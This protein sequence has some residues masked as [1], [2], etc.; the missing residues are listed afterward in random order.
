MA[1]ALANLNLFAIQVQHVQRS[2]NDADGTQIGAVSTN[3]LL[4]TG[5]NYTTV[6]APAVY[7]TNRFTHWTYDRFP[8][9]SFRDAW[10][11]SQNPMSFVLVGQT[12]NTAHYLPSTRDTDGDGLPDG[13]EIEYFNTLSYT[14]T[15]DPDGDGVPLATE[16][17]NGLHPLLGNSNSL[18]GVYWADSTMINVNLQG[19]PSYVLRSIPAGTVN[20]SAVVPPNTA[21]TTP[22]RPGGNT[23]GYWSL[24]GVRQQDP[25]GVAL[26]QISFVVTNTDREA[27]A[28]L[29]SNDSDGD[30]VPDAYEQVYYGSLTNSATSDTDGDGR[31]LLQEYTAGS[32]PHI[33]NMSSEGGVYWA[34]SALMPVNL[35]SYSQY[36]IISDPAGIINQSAFVPDGTRITTPNMAQESF[37]YWTLDGVQQRDGWGMAVRQISFVVEGADREA[38]AHL[39]AGDTDTDG[40]P[41]A[42]EQTYYGTL[43]NDAN[44]DTDGDGRTLLQEYTAG[45]QPHIGNSSS[46]G[47]VY[48]A[49]SALMPVN[50]SNYS[51]YR[52]ISAPTGAIN[53][54]AFVPDGTTITTPEMT[55]ESFG[56]WTLDGVQQR[57]AWGLSVRKISFVVDG[58]DRE[59]VA[60]LFAGDTD[61]DGVPDAFEQTYY[62][63][64]ANDNSSDTDN[65]GRTL[66]QEYTEGSQPHIGNSSSEGGVYWADSEMI[67]VDLVAVKRGICFEEAAVTVVEGSLGVNRIAEIPVF[68]VGP[69]SVTVYAVSG[70]A[71]TADYIWPAAPTTLTWASG[72]AETKM[73]RIPIKTDSLFEQDEVFYLMLGSPT[74][75][76]QI[77]EQRG[78]AVTIKDAN[79]SDKLADALDNLILSWTTS[80]TP[81]WTPQSAMTFDGEDAAWSGA[82]A[83]NKISYVRTSVTGTGTVSFAWCVTGQG[84]LS[85][86]D[87]TKVLLAI[88]NDTDWA[89]QSLRLDNNVT[90]ALKWEY[91]QGGDGLGRAYLDRVVWIPGG[92][93]AV[94]V[95]VIADSPEGGMASGSG[96]YIPGA[97]ISL[98]AKPRAG[99]LFTGW[100]S[101]VP[102][103]YPLSASQTLTVGV[104]DLTLTAHFVKVPV[105]TGIPY[106]PEGGRVTGTGLCLPGKSVTLTATPVTG[107]AFTQWS[108]NSQ[109]ASRTIRTTI[110]VTL[111]AAFKR[112]ADVVPPTIG[113]IQ[114]Q[115]AMVGVPF[116]VPVEMV[117]EALATVTLSGLPAGLSYT[118]ATQSISGVPTV[119]VTNRIVTITAKNANLLPTTRTFLLTIDPLPVWAKGTFSGLVGSEALGS[120]SATM[121]I[122][123]IGNMAGKF[124]L[125]GTNFLFSA[126]AYSAR[127]PDGAFILITT[128]KVG[129]VAW[130]MTLVVSQPVIGDPSN[131]V[132]DT[133]SIADGVLEGR[134]EQVV[135]YRSLWG[136]PGMSAL[137]APLFSGYYTATLPGGNQFG[138]GYLTFTVDKAGMVKTV[139][140]LADGTAIS[141]SG[142]LVLDE[143][144]RVWTVIYTAPTAY[145]GGGLFGVVE[146]VRSPSGVV[147]VQV[148]NSEPFIWENFNPLATGE[149]GAGFLRELGLVG[150]WYDTV[151]NLYRYFGNR[152]L[153]VSTENTPAPEVLVG[154]NRYDAACWDP[155]GL[156]LKVVTNSAGVLTGLVTPKAGTA[157]KVAGEYNY[158]TPTN[159][160]GMTIG[161]TRATGLFKGSFKAWFDYGTTHTSKTITYEGVLTPEKVDPSDPVA[162]RGFFLW[163][164]KAPSPAPL[165]P[166]YFYWSYDLQLL[167]EE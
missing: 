48:W 81:K 167:L 116:E 2:V 8:T 91:K 122:T 50:L 109:I 94:Q 162:G 119:P 124:T 4:G 134:S 44:S 100:T 102:L 18:G 71:T 83:S 40:V 79:R 29:F 136:D 146:F 163:R 111:V 21:I 85:L 121:S 38:V 53:Q 131:M 126:P 153:S 87:G 3:A 73:V 125:R 117:S 159:A 101:G 86:L 120:G 56:Y 45:S 39:F 105:V 151:G 142:M 33:G 164:D 113:E 12:T 166:Y 82:L 160:V 74:S 28:Y 128:A 36:R 90:H 155:D 1:L 72:V 64:L 57:D 103:T 77:G 161:L 30:Q 138:S 26:P 84:I 17:A 60:H 123:A 35:A 115:R 42:F 98:N 47:G 14:G 104:S 106:P 20:Q 129:T 127:E 58:T 148:Y 150:G 31:T 54:S 147:R 93:T 145:R 165:S 132:P 27:I 70:T 66:L 15:S 158:E 16:Y 135:L 80:G 51:Q 7:S 55:Q 13:Y 46:E 61:T 6:T 156:S 89:A 63:T 97:R 149:Y 152:V 114:P 108:D 25:F 67:A 78:C 96:T 52:I 32:L 9:N 144:G 5:T 154:T 157:V 99:W 49:D 95:N 11:R 41:D 76:R 23:F 43:T 19:Y 110:D 130:P 143:T 24:D 92:K 107:W 112:I 62:G 59:A 118:Q 139:G 10:G 133:L 141:L 34:D 68:A 75:G 22:E 69:A 65:D 88:T 37:G 137:L 140:K